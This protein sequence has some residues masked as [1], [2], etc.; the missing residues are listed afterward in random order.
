MVKSTAMIQ[1]SQDL[2][3]LLHNLDFNQIHLMVWLLVALLVLII[4][5][6]KLRRERK[7]KPIHHYPYAAKSLL[8]NTEYTFFRKLRTA[9][10]GSYM[11][12]P[13]VRLEDLCYVTDKRNYLRYRGYIRSRHVDFVI[14]DF[15]CNALLAIELDDASHEDRTAHQIDD[16][17]NKLFK[18]I[19][20]PLY[21]VPVQKNYQKDLDLI[22][23]ALEK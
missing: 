7:F 1:T 8:T 16:F 19:G 13:K 5:V 15:S 6:G 22:I 20:I 11:I 10:S 2:K 9:I 14:C 18:K 23:E 17:K 21:R 4:I 3:Q 12:C